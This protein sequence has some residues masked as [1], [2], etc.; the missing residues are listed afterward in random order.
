MKTW[1]HKVL[2]QGFMVSQSFTTPI[3][4]KLSLPPRLS[5]KKGILRDIWYAQPNWCSLCYE[6]CGTQQ[7]H[8]KGE[9]IHSCL[10]AVYDNVM[11]QSGIRSWNTL[12]SVPV[13]SVVPLHAAYQKL[14]E[15]WVCRLCTFLRRFMTHMR[16]RG[17]VVGNMHELNYNIGS[18]QLRY[19]VAREMYKAFSHTD[20]GYLS[21]LHTRAIHAVKLDEVYENLSFDNMFKELS[22][23]NVEAA[24]RS[25]LENQ[26]LSTEAKM[27]YG[28]SSSTPKRIHPRSNAQNPEYDSTQSSAT[29]TRARNQLAQNRAAVIRCI[30]GDI[31]LL[32]N[33]NNL[34][35]CTPASVSSSQRYRVSPLESQTLTCNT[36]PK[37]TLFYH[38]LA[39]HIVEVMPMYVFHVSAQEYVSSIERAWRSRHFEIGTVPVAQKGFFD[40]LY[41]P[42]LMNAHIDQKQKYCIK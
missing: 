31:Y 25:I 5:S 21:A 41:S 32:Y 18:I 3:P 35:S 28:I 37:L 30:Y 4:P 38:S 12:R 42:S 20:S 14:D 22:K 1:S 8:D 17:F 11:R 33:Y 6:P 19:R 2:H 24:Y 29:L 36:F 7:S 23:I 34:F 27:M 16:S 39:R 40:N 9:R 15:E 10:E 26:S 13:S